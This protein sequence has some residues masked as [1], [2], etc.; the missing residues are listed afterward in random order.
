MVEENLSLCTINSFS[1]C[2]NV[3]GTVLSETHPVVQG[4][5]C[6]F[7]LSEVTKI[8]QDKGPVKY[9]SGLLRNMGSGT[10]G[11]RSADRKFELS[12]RL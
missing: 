8:S 4:K 3:E 11:A 9:T 5:S 1:G 7:H 2:D 6:R 12:A 10:V